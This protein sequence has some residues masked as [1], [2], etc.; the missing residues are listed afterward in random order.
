M[1][2]SKK[3]KPFL[4]LGFFALSI[5]SIP[6]LTLASCGSTTPTVDETT[7]IVGIKVKSEPVISFEE[8][9]ETKI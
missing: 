4:F 6:L 9:K 1:K 2:K 5:T 7:N 8:S 3:N